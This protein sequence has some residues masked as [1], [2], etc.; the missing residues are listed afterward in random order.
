[1]FAFN[2]TDKPLADEVKVKLGENTSSVS[3]SLDAYGSAI[4]EV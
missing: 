3:V 2:Y 4:Y 1:L